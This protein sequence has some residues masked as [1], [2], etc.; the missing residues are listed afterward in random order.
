[1]TLITLVMPQEH[2]IMHATRPIR[3]KIT[4][5]LDI[6]PAYQYI[7]ESKTFSL[8][9]LIWCIIQIG[10]VVLVIPLGEHKLSTPV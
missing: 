2:V 5:Y 7:K 6:L 4:T 9:G 1:M 3:G 8:S 10:Y